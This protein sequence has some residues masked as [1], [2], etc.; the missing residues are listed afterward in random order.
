MGVSLD[1]NFG[2]GGSPSAS[3]NGTGQAVTLSTTWTRYS[4]TFTMPSI[5]G[6]TLGSN[7][8]HYTTLIFWLSSGATNNSRAGNIGVQSGTFTVW[9]V[10]LEFGSVATT[11]EKVDRGIEL[12]RC[13]RHY[14][15]TTVYCNGYN[16]AGGGAWGTY[17]LSPPMRIAPTVAYSGQSYTNASSFTTYQVTASVYVAQINVTATGAGFGTATATFTAEL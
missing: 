15:A 11:L 16:A 4:L 7:S 10:Q 13:R 3:V 5:I 6:K 14:L 2:T 9:G 17:M 12:L 1:Q 8:D